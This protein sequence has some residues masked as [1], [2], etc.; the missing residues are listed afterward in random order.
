MRGLAARRLFRVPP[1]RKDTIHLQTSMSSLGFES[2]PY[3][4]TAVCQRALRPV[5][6]GC[7][8][9][10]LDNA[11]LRS[12]LLALVEAGSRVA[13]TSSKK[14]VQVQNATKH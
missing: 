3:G 10:D 13:Q 1:C 14:C 9:F 2:S 5:G 8:A 6:V 7:R 11:S 4:T 12:R